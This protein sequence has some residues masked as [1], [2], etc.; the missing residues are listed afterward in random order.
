MRA[1][2]QRQLPRR[3]GGH[4][5]GE[6][7]GRCVAARDLADPWS[8]VLQLWI[9][10]AFMLTLIYHIRE[11]TFA[12]DPRQALDSGQEAAIPIYRLAPATVCSVTNHA[13]PMTRCR[14]GQTFITTRAH[15]AEI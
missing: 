14:G 6:H 8:E 2:F 7:D 11:S 15:R 1:V 13:R 5:A 3:V 10:A 4:V 9:D 12:D